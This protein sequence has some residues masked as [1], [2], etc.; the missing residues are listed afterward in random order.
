MVSLSFVALMCVSQVAPPL[1]RPALPHF[2]GRTENVN[3]VTWSGAELPRVFERG[4]QPPLSDEDLL[5]MA[6]AGFS[7]KELVKVIEERRCACDASADGLIRLRK[8]GVG[9]EV[10]AAVSLHALP[11][12]R[13]LNLLLTLDFTGQSRE[14]REAYLYVFVDDGPLTRVLTADLNTLL[15]RRH[16]GE[17]MTDH[18]DLLIAKQVRRISLAGAL[19]LKTA[20]T[21]QVLVVTSANPT[22]KHPSELKPEE[23]AKAQR[24]TFDFPRASLLSVC[25]LSAG[26]KRDAVLEYK[27]KYM[28]S[29]FECEWN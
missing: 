17:T 14:A 10:L 6:Q 11:P 12:N 29:R 9:P 2:P 23:L 5:K 19:P 16:A 3:L 13:Q 4:E 18:S 20:G 28:G 22:L 24:Y 1:P 7:A 25:R 21:R 15:A 26:Y 8:A 27:W